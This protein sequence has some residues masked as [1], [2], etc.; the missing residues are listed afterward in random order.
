MKEHDVLVLPSII[1]GRALV[2]QEAP[3]VF[4]DHYSQYRGENLTGRKN[5]FVVP[6]EPRKNC[7]KIEW[8]AKIK[9]LPEISRHCRE[10]AKQHLEI[11]RRLNHKLMLANTI[12]K[13]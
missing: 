4:L 3:T 12:R 7:R 11:L 2:Q 5:G 9:K 10:K 1:E 8:Y 6:I 13:Q